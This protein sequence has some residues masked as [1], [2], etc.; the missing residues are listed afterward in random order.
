MT[1]AEI[2]SIIEKLADIARVLSDADPYDKSEIFRQ[3]GL[4]LTYHP[5]RQ[6]VEAIAATLGGPGRSLVVSKRGNAPM[7][8][9]A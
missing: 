9:H 4:R 7:Q 2:R 1:E 3:L 5:G 6:L 8:Y